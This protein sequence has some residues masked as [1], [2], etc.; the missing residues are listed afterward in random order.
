MRKHIAKLIP[1]KELHQE[2]SN[3]L[4][5]LGYS[6]KSPKFLEL[7]TSAQMV[8]QIKSFDSW[9]ENC[10]NLVLKHFT[11]KPISLNVKSLLTIFSPEL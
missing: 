11:G 1:L 8:K 4:K 10:K 9:M 3:D 7:K 6:K 5:K 2:V